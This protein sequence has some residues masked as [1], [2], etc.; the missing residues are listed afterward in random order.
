MTSHQRWRMFGATVV[1]IAATAA[2]TQLSG[3][4]AARK[5]AVPLNATE[6]ILEA[7]RTYQVVGLGDNHGDQRLSEFRLALLGDPRLASVVNDIVVEFGSARYQDLMDRFVRGESVP[8]SELRH[9]WE[10]TTLPNPVWDRPIYENVFR[11]IRAVNAK[12]PASRQLRVLLAGPPIDWDAVKT[13]EEYRTWSLQR[14]RFTF[15]L[16]QREVI[17]R[18]RR[19]LAIF[20]DGHFQARTARPGRVWAGRLAEA[21]VQLLAI[22]SA[23]GRIA[24]LQPDAANWPTPSLAFVRGTPIGGAGYEFFYGPMPPGEYFAANSKFEDHWDAVLY[25]G[26]AATFPPR[27]ALTF[28]RCSEPDYVA[29]RVARMEIAGMGARPGTP[30]LAE[31]LQQECRP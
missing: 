24:E 7:F 29:M 21:G 30:T 15:D 22:A 13:A 1:F 19:A 28:P 17:A 18:N 26:S 20:G 25:L 3:A 2:A 6:A 9:V 12:L 5:P 23:T 27:S 4:Q 11:T 16:I 14:D 10:N 31:R 8:D